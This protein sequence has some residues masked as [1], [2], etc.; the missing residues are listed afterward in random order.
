VERTVVLGAARTPFG[1]FGGALSSLSAPELG[2][3]AIR[4]AIDRSGVE[5]SELAHSVFGIVVQAGVGQIPSRQANY[6]AGL[7]FELTTET[8]NQVCASGIRSMTLAETMIRAGDYEVVLAGGMESM[9][10]APY[11]MEKARWG[12]RMGDFAAIDAMMHDGLIDAFEHVNMIRF[13]TDGA[14]KHNISREQQDEWALRSHQRA[15]AATEEGK[16]SE[17]IVGIKVSG[18]KGE[19]NYVEADEPIR[20]DASLEKLAALEPLDEG[21]TVTA[22]NAPGVTDGAGAFVL[23]SES[24]AEKRGLEPM[25]T[26]VAHAKVAENPPNLPTVPGNAGKLALEKAGWKAEDLDLVEINEAFAVVAIHSTDILGVD[27]GIVNVSGGAVALGHPIGAS[28]ARI[29]MTLLYEL[30]RRGGG[31]GLATLCSGGGQGDAVLVE[32]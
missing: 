22:G 30:R 3:V 10:N 23:A 24:F 4:E 8:L 31:R 5:D 16:L 21:G 6:H 15:A 25:G 32:V 12:A 13:G 20:F 7:P 9:S 14:R 26:I 19:T 18:K 1:K 17:E 2:G 29:V 11:L 28:G 27:P